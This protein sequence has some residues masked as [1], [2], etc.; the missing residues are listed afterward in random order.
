MSRANRL[1]SRVIRVAKEFN[2]VRA[3][4]GNL[5]NRNTTE[6]SSLV[7]A[8]NELQTAV[9]SAAVINDEQVSASTA[10]SSNK[11]VAL[12]DALKTETLGG[13]DAAYDLSLIPL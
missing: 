6:K 1:E 11:I 8:I 12:L 3:Q 4:A 9:Q 2:D 13:A 7:A 10:Y 5:A